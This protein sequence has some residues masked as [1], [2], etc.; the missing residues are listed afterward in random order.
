M[1][2]RLFYQMKLY[3][4]DTEEEAKDFVVKKSIEDMLTREAEEYECSVEE[5]KKILIEEWGIGGD[6]GYGI[7]VSGDL[8]K[9][10]THIERIDELGVY[11]GD[12]EAS[13]QAEKDGIKLIPLE[14][15]PKEY[16]YNCYRF[17]DTEENRRILE[18]IKTNL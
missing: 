9:G 1:A 17:I 12:L 2:K 13:I 14:E 18:E 4:Y 16:P 15:N 3:D 5:V 6:K 7:F 10:L 11:D 8:P